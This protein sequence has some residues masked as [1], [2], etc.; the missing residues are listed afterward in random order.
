LQVTPAT[1][2]S[3]RIL[4]VGVIV[5]EFSANGP[6]WMDKPYGYSYQFTTRELRDPSVTIIPLLEPNTRDKPEIAK[7]LKLTFSGVAPMDVTDAG[8]LATL[9]VIVSGRTVNALP[10]ELAA[11]ETAVS[12]GVGLLVWGGLGDVNPGFADPAVVRLGGFAEAQW[13]ADTNFVECEVIA[14]HPILGKLKAGDKVRLQPSGGYGVLKPGG[15]GLLKLGPEARIHT[16]GPGSAEDREG[17]V[18]YPI[19][20]SSL[21]KGRIVGCSFPAFRQLEPAFDRAV[22][23]KFILRCVQWLAERPATR[24]TTMAATAP[25][26]TTR[27][28]TQ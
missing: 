22:G 11:I 16:Y 18:F 4:K 23:G 20:T 9:D 10:A 3:A 1:T 5:S 19:Y 14:P 21:G 17:F 24:A 26:A 12:G 8:T 7:A 2:T 15:A 13:G 25:T 27:T 6:N 28:Q